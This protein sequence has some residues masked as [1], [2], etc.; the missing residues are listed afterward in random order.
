[1]CI[2]QCLEQLKVKCE[3][4]IDDLIHDVTA[5]LFLRLNGCTN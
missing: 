1:M 2:K 4:H 3:V 5:K